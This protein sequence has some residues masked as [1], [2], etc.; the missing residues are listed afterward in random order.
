MVE[1][2]TT[3]AFTITTRF[4]V[5]V[6][7][8]YHYAFIKTGKDRRKAMFRDFQAGFRD[9]Y[10]E[11]LARMEDYDVLFKEPASAHRAVQKALR[12]P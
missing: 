7:A 4:A 8:I 3:A 11:C 2:V 1:Y 6:L 5:D 9:A 12:D 10:E